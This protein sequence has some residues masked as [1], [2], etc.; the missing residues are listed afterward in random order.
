[1]IGI[2][3]NKRYCTCA[4]CVALAK[5]NNA[6]GEDNG[7]RTGN[8]IIFA[9]K[10]VRAIK[11]WV[12]T[13]DPDKELVFP[14][15]AYFHT[16]NAPVKEV[17]GKYVPVNEDVIPDESIAVMYAPLENDFTYS[18]DD[19]RN[20]AIN[21]TLTKWQAVTNNI[22]VYSYG[23]P[24]GAKSMLPMNNLLTMGGSYSMAVKNNYT[25]YL[26]ES[27]TTSLYAG[28]EKLKTYISSSI[29]WD[30]SRSVD[31][32]AYEFIDFYYAP[33][34]T[35]FKQ[36]Y[37]DLKQFQTYQIDTLGLRVGI[38]SPKYNEAQYWPYGS[39]MHFSNALDDML[40]KI[41][42][43]KITDP[44]AY[45]TYFDRINIEKLWVNYAL[46]QF[47]SS[48]YNAKDYLELVDFMNEYMLEYNVG[49]S[50]R[51]SLVSA[52]KKLK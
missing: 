23:V 52:W 49:T 50:S 13:I 21:S 9:N 17:N 37:A 7:E 6:N 18:F 29:W 16:V 11:S 27:N 22:I 45:Q 4:N 26:E 1:M 33:V 48:K 41:K 36:Y 8:F 35:E 15:F 47:Y 3:D 44:V 42:S 10:V 2:N 34:A 14:I 24:Y 25:G 43:L 19:K 5:K 30:A 46:C 39:V 20:L 12:K 32:Y 38:Q 28:Q 51:E 31:D 40:E